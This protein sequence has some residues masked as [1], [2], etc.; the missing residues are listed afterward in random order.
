MLGT[1]VPNSALVLVQ[2]LVDLCQV[3]SQPISIPPLLRHHKL[4]ITPLLC[5]AVRDGVTISM[6]DDLRQLQLHALRQT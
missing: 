3:D 6:P 4:L 1:S 5:P 2:L